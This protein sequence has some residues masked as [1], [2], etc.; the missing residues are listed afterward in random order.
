M[1]STRRMI[2]CSYRCAL[3]LNDYQWGIHKVSTG[4][5]NIIHLTSKKFYIPSGLGRFQIE[6]KSYS[7]STNHSNK[8]RYQNEEYDISRLSM[9]EKIMIYKSAIKK[10]WVAY[11]YTF[12]SLFPGICKRL[13]GKE[14]EFDNETGSVIEKVDAV[15]KESI[16]NEFNVNFNASPEDIEKN[17]MMNAK[18]MKKRGDELL[19]V[20]REE[21][22]VTNKKELAQ[23]ISEQ[24]KLGTICLSQFM[25][26]YRQGRDNELDKMINEYFKDIDEDEEKMEDIES[27]ATKIDS[28]EHV[29][30][31]RKP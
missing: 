13:F 24:I 26:G 28:T 10:A 7:S 20:A 21:T 31:A 30:T 6:N 8:E 11:I 3:P 27:I 18:F 9:K 14:Y 15:E 1:K 25:E 5:T 2:R 17:I 19:K 23:W 4:S 16:T 29:T 22:G 12:E